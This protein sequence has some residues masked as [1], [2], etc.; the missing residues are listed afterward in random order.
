MKNQT[1]KKF[2]HK[3]RKKK[4]FKPLELVHLKILIKIMYKIIFFII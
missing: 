2:M 3:I 1:I 4:Q